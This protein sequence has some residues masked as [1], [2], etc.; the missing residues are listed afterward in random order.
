MVMRLEIKKSC[1]FFW[2]RR[3]E[4]VDISQCCMKCFLGTSDNRVFGASK[5]APTV[6]EIEIGSDDNLF[7]PIAYY[8]C[9]LA[10]NWVYEK[11]THVAFNPAAGEKVEIANAEISLLITGAKQI[12]F[13]DYKPKATGFFTQRQR[14]CRNWIFAN[15]VNDGMQL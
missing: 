2:L 1:E 5:K 8:L 9:G 7:P 15:Y 13:A 10:K 14:D 6:I 11:N 4:A 12:H 3:I